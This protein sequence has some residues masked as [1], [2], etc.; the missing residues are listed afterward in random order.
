MWF[1]KL[2][3]MHPYFRFYCERLLAGII[4]IAVILLVR[5]L[6]SLT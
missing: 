1:D 2:T 4:L 6:L 3:T 5:F